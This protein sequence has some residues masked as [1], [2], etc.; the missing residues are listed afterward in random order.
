M[1]K[2]K[3]CGIKLSNC[4]SGDRLKITDDEFLRCIYCFTIH[5]WAT[6]QA[7]NLSKQNTYFKNQL[8]SSDKRGGERR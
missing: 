6:G 7:V 5:S 8:G 1:L 4:Q 2:C 3:K